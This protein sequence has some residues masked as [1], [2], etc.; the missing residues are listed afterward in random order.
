MRGCFGVYAGLVRLVHAGWQKRLPVGGLEP[1][2]ACAPLASRALQ[3]SCRNTVTETV[4]EDVFF[5][6]QVCGCRNFAEAR[7]LNPNP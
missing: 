7:N 5:E 1:D 2:G 6:V 4:S 3:Q